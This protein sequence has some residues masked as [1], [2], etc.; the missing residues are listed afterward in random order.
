MGTPVLN[1]VTPPVPNHSIFSPLHPRLKYSRNQVNRRSSKIILCYEVQGSIRARGGSLTVKRSSS[2]LTV[3]QVELL[4]LHPKF[5][6]EFL[7]KTRSYVPDFLLCASAD[8]KNPE[9][10]EDLDAFTFAAPMRTYH[11]DYRNQ[12][13]QSPVR[14]FL[15]KAPAFES[16]L[17][18]PFLL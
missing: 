13:I 12:G 11:T 5:W 3:V 16:T 9:E 18:L 10:V 15:T 14:G 2:T 1:S 6:V 17:R 4:C 8:H 7:C